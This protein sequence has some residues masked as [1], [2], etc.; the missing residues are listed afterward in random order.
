MGSCPTLG[1]GLSEETH[2]LTKR[3]FIGE[4]RGQEPPR[5]AL[6]RG[7]VA[8]GFL[9][10]GLASQVVLDQHLIQST[11]GHTDLGQGGCQRGGLWEVGNA[12]L[13]TFPSSSCWRRLISSVFITGLLDIKK[14]PRQ[15]VPVVRRGQSSPCP[16]NGSVL[17]GGQCPSVPSQRLCAWLWP[18]RE[19]GSVAR[20]SSSPTSS[21]VPH[22]AG[23]RTPQ[24]VGP[25]SIR[26]LGLWT[27]CPGRVGLWE[28]PT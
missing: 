24:P 1:A 15:L 2:G 23:T 13:W 22:P 3:G 25:G 19:P 10:M 17:D 11:L 14:Q 27:Q 9:L 21:S 28:R 18:P 7:L 26:L 20:A 5:A 8:S 12:P 6:P 4:Q 16:P